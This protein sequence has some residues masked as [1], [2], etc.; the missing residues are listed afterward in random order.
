MTQ[1]DVVMGLIETDE[2][3]TVLDALI[4]Y[5]GDHDW[6]TIPEPHGLIA[7]AKAVGNPSWSAWQPRET[8]PKDGTHFLAADFTHGAIG[9]G[10]F[11]GHTMAQPM[12][13]VVHWYDGDPSDDAPGPGRV[14]SGFYTSVNEIEPALTFA[15]TDWM[16]LPDKRR[17]AS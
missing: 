17:T 16:H 5:C 9:F 10:Y 1:T 7:R 14:G 2:A 4:A 8:A 3:K 15:F 12:M 13:A 11:K 6:G